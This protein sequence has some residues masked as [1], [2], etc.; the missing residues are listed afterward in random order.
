MSSGQH[1]ANNEWVSKLQQ[2]KSPLSWSQKPNSIKCLNRWE[3]AKLSFKSSSENW[4]L[5][6]DLL[7]IELVLAG[8]RQQSD[9]CCCCYKDRPRNGRFGG[10]ALGTWKKSKEVVCVWKCGFSTFVHNLY[11]VLRVLWVHFKLRVKN[12]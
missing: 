11:F 8:F 12:S 6:E 2:W 4:N 10:F 1:G 5:L 7:F 3:T 9:R